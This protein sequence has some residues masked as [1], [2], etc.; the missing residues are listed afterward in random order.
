MEGSDGYSRVFDF[1]NQNF[2]GARSRDFIEVDDMAVIFARV[3]FAVYAGGC[4]SG[5]S[6]CKLKFDIA[7]LHFIVDH[8]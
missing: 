3:Y 8:E 2:D 4:V 6:L 5:L 7:S 1:H